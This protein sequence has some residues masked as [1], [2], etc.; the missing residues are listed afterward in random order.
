MLVS[1]T[2]D[3]L[4]NHG[5]L[6]ERSGWRLSPAYDLNPVPVDVKPRVHA[7]AIDE[8]DGTA[9]LDLAM[10]VA[11]MFGM[12]GQAGARQLRRW[13]RRSGAGETLRLASALRR[14]RWSGCPA[15]SITTI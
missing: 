13:A 9:S 8:T 11:P 14:M 12:T 15:P 7:L 2:D 4:R 1:N 6:R 10:E 5:F 3:H